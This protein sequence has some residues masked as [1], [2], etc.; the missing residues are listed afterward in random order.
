MLKYFLGN[1]KYQVICFNNGKEALDCLKNK[2]TAFGLLLTDLDMPEMTGLE[3]ARQGKTLYPALPIIVMSGSATGQDRDEIFSL[4]ADF[5][6]KP[7][8]L[9][10]L[11]ERID[12]KITQSSRTP[13]VFGK[14]RR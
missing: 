10:D 8:K 12:A 7:F 2:H 4:G 6:P 11:L 9:N 1:T 5:I 3:L 13:Q 14:E